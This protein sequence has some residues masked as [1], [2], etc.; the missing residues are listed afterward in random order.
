MFNSGLT[1]QQIKDKFSW[2]ACK[3]LDDDKDNDGVIIK[4]HMADFLEK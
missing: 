4:E 1:S 2:Q 3:K